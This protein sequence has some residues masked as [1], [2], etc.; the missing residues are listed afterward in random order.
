MDANANGIV[1]AITSKLRCFNIYESQF[2]FCF[3]VGK[4]YKKKKKKK[5][6]YNGLKH[7]N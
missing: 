5:F 3:F 2:V 6:V 7:G 4:D 1:R